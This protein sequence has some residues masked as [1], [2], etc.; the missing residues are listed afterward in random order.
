MQKNLLVIN[1]YNVNP[2]GI[3]IVKSFLRIT[4]AEDDAML[5]LLLDSAIEYAENKFEM[6]IGKKNYLYTICGDY[7]IAIPRS[8]VIAVNSVQVDG[9]DISF[10]LN[11]RYLKISDQIFEKEVKINFT[12][13]NSNISNI[14]KIAILRHVFFLYENR[15]T[16][17]FDTKDVDTIYQP[18]VANVYNI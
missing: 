6:V 3:D 4:T 16:L 9:I 5:Q 11:G 18:L 10:Q 7:N 13:E 8:P 2:I 17:K 14:L 12:A 15:S 1:N